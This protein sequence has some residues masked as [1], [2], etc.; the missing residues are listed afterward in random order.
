[1][2]VRQDYEPAPSDYF[3]LKT[4]F[5]MPIKKWLGANKPEIV[6]RA[7]QFG[8]YDEVIKEKIDA[9]E[10]VAQGFKGPDV[11]AQISRIQDEIIEKILHSR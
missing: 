1:M 11:G 6:N 10:I 3:I 7:K 9:N 5:R 2:V 4:S 8:V